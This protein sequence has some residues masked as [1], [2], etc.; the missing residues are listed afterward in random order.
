MCA[1]TGLPLVYLTGITPAGLNASSQDEIEIF[2]DT[3]A[4]N[5][6]IY[7]PHVSKVLNLV[8]LSLFGEIDPDI[9]F[10]WN[11]LK[12]ITDEQRATIRKTEAETDQMHITNGVLFPE[13]V[14]TRIADEEDSPYHGIDLSRELPEPVTQ[15]GDPGPN[16]FGL[17]PLEQQ[18][19]A[20][21]TGEAEPAEAT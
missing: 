20:V 21:K 13:E 18:P 8:Q 11:Q 16:E 3:A 12:V 14:R 2:Q 19:Q 15:N 10:E 5:Q 9:G 4:A 17:D 7:T 1:P 6:E